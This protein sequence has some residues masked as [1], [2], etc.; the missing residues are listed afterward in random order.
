MS[1]KEKAEELVD[2][3][4]WKAVSTKK[5]A[6]QC[7]IIAVDEIISQWLN[8]DSRTAKLKYWQEVKLETEKL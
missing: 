4:F 5:Q 8:E 6:K 1:P 2:K 7:A 3:F